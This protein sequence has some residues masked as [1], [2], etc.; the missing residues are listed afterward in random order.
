MPRRIVGSVGLILYFCLSCLPFSRAV[1][2]PL[3][4]LPW[5]MPNL[6]SSSSQAQSPYLKSKKNGLSSFS[7]PAF[8][9]LLS[10]VNMAPTDIPLPFPFRAHPLIYSL[11]GAR[12]LGGVAAVG[13]RL[14][15]GVLVVELDCCGWMDWSRAGQGQSLVKSS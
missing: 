8:S 11:Q 10:F 6:S 3:T 9:P 2:P 14:L 13:A 12:G 5:D 7:T 4:L 15:G 1:V